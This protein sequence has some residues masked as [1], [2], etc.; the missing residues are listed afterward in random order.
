M[1]ISE[2][3]QWRSGLLRYKAVKCISPQQQE[4]LSMTSII[5]ITDLCLTTAPTH[6]PRSSSLLAQYN[7]LIWISLQSLSPFSITWYL[8][9]AYQYS[10]SRSKPCTLTTASFLSEI[11]EERIGILCQ[12]IALDLCSTNIKSLGVAVTAKRNQL[13]SKG[14]KG[15]PQDRKQN[16]SLLL[17]S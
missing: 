8:L 15:F 10:T 7:Q 16:L 11:A 9:I 5:H 2:G 6:A 13:T 14:D 4:A 12:E 17:D 3:A 1:T